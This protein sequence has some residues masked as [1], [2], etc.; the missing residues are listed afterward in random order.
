MV[1][2]EWPKLKRLIWVANGAKHTEASAWKKKD[3][4]LG[5]VT[6]AVVEN[7]L[8]YSSIY[9]LSQGIVDVEETTKTTMTHWETGEKSSIFVE[10]ILSEGFP[11]WE[12]F[13]EKYFPD[14]VA[15]RPL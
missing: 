5:P 10:E 2:D 4:E 13:Y 14:L 11:Y 15:K 9:N 8:G 6:N 3:A 1:A 7:E 12:K